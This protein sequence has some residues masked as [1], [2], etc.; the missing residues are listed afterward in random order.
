MNATVM[1][2]ST[3]ENELTGTVRICHPA[4][5]GTNAKLRSNGEGIEHELQPKIFLQL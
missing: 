2:S 4:L 1:G 5:R 3:I